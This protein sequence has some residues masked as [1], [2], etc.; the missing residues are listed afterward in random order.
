MSSERRRAKRITDFLEGELLCCDTVY[1]GMILDISENGLYFV[2]A[3]IKHVKDFTKETIV[4]LFLKIPSSRALNLV[5]RVRW[6]SDKS[7]NHGDSFCLGLE[8]IMPPQQYIELARSM[9]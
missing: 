8:V 7:T 6:F 2:T 4:E 9:K 1:P 3:T 5:C